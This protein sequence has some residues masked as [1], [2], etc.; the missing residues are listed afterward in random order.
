MFK[1]KAYKYKL[2]TR[3]LKS[4]LDAFLFLFDKLIINTNNETMNN[5]TMNNENMNNETMNNETMN[6]KTKNNK[7]K[8]NKLID[9]YIDIIILSFFNKQFNLHKTYKDLI[10]ELQTCAILHRFVE[11][12]D[13]VYIP[14]FQHKA[15]TYFLYDNLLSKTDTRKRYIRKISVYLKNNGTIQYSHKYSNYLSAMNGNNSD[16]GGGGGGGGKA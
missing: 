16:G 6:N 8:N 13:T 12:F 2:L 4:V 5:E 15:G 7:T 10:D 11:Y 3:E 9:L 14:L 1:T